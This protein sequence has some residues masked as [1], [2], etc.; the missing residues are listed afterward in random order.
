ML[1]KLPEIPDGLFCANDRQI[2]DRDVNVASETIVIKT[3]L[4]VRYST[5]R[6]PVKA[7]N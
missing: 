4:I 2:E 1:L 7:E 5:S 3:D 6:Q